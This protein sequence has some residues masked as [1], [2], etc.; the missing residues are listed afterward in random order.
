MISNYN[1]KFVCNYNF[2][3]WFPI[4]IS[5]M[6]TIIISKMLAIIIFQNYNYNCCLADNPNHNNLCGGLKGRIWLIYWTSPNSTNK[7]IYIYI[8]ININIYIYKYKYIYIYIYVLS[9]SMFR[10]LNVIYT[11]I[12]IYISN[13][14][15]RTAR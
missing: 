15:R 8:Y 13:I 3:K 5:K 10:Q 11:Y 7:K 1:F 2:Q 12:Y 6:F 14:G 9:D 4:I